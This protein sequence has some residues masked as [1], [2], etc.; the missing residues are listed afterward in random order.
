M[1][2]PAAFRAFPP[3]LVLLWLLAG[4]AIAAPAINK[5]APLLFHLPDAGA[6]PWLFVMP[7][8]SQP[9]GVVAEILQAA[10]REAGRP[11]RYEFQP[12]ERASDS[13]RRGSADGALFFSTT[14]PPTRE[15]VL[16]E[17]VAQLDTVLVTMQD[18]PLNFRLPSNLREKKL[19]TLTDELYPPLALLSMKG[20][21][22]QTRAKSEQAALMMLRYESCVAAVVSGPAWRWLS[23]RSDWSDLRVEPRPLLKENLVL[24]FAAR[25]RAFADAVNR[26]LRDM[27]ASGLLAERVNR[28]LAEDAHTAAIESADDPMLR[29]GRR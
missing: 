14:R 20:T 9:E 29:L 12:R 21:L 24:G 6:P 28:W 2:F 23:S 13:L 25:E 1:Q 17:P 27:R 16:T 11:L 26:A 4:Q 19:C 22:R 10:A 3:S 15:L 5:P 7:G 8:A 18:Q